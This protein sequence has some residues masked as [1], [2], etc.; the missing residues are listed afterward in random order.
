MTKSNLDLWNSVQE[1]NPADTKPVSFG[2]K[3]TAIDAYSQIKRATEKFGSYG[4]GWGISAIVHTFVPDTKMVMGEAQF[5]YMVDEDKEGSFPVTSSIL[6]VNAKSGKVDDEFAKKLETDMITK[7]L[8]RLGFNADVFMGLYDDNRYVASM[9]EKF[10]AQVAPEPVN[11]E[12]VD[13]AVK[14]YKGLINA[15]V[16]GEP[17]YLK[18]QAIDRRLSNDERIA[19]NESLGQEKHEGG[20]LYRTLVA[21]YLKMKP[22]DLVNSENFIDTSV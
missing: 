9:K 22:A 8:S 16:E 19:V 10:A 12:H 21:D 15:D 2:R 20:R 11:Q 13:Y 14:T 4:S 3:F 5:F 1:T 17:D 6:Y 18:M 7:A